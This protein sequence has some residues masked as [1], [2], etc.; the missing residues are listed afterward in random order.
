MI[1]GGTDLK[2]L[3]KKIKYSKK[4]ISYVTLRKG[5]KNPNQFFFK[6]YKKRS[7]N[8]LT[9]KSQMCPVIS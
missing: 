5:V 8:C 9:C 6:I 2:I 7:R 4:K 1:I 3:L